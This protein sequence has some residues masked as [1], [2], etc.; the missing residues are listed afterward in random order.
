VGGLGGAAGTGGEGGAAGMSGMS[1][2]GGTGGT[3]GS[4][5]GPAPVLLGAAG[6]Y[7][8]LAEAAI[9]SVPTSAVTGNVGL[10]PAA[11]TYITGFPLTNVGAY[12][13]T[14]EVTGQLFAAD[15]DP[16][17]P[18]NLTT[19]IGAM[20][21]AYTDAAGRPTPDFVN[22]GAGDIGGF[23]LTPG[24]YSWGSSVTL[25]ADVT[26]DGGADDTWILQITGDVIMSAGKNVALTGG[27]R[28]KN[29]VWQ[30]AGMVDVGTGAH[31]QGIV[32]SK[33]AITM[34]TGAS[35]DGRLY[36]QTMIALDS[37]TVTQPA[38]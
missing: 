29:V 33:T 24:L 23:K 25:P 37:S 22:I 19:A 15:N 38:P 12:W 26:L 6:D 13:T 32:L 14:P 7:V 3:G 16:P 21:A 35:I 27:A 17:T 9:S 2:M 1:G 31:L 34:G 8:I 11:A 36:A 18:S 28:A 20:M 4:P 10:S 5:I 30:V